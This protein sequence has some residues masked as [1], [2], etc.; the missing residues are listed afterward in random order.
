VAKV[1]LLLHLPVVKAIS[2]A[3]AASCTLD[4][5]VLHL[6]SSFFTNI[7]KR[8][9]TLLYKSIISIKRVFATVCIIM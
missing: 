3:L 6:L 5:L 4:V 1:D 8:G 9:V 7:F 2:A